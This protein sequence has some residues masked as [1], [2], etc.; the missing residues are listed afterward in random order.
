MDL[1]NNF[2]TEQYPVGYLWS[3]E[4]AGALRDCDKDCHKCYHREVIFNAKKYK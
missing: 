2:F 3:I 1:A 4:T